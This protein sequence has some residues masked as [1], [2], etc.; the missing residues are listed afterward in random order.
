MHEDQVHNPDK[1]WAK[2]KRANPPSRIATISTFGGVAD[3]VSEAISN[4]KKGDD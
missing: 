1:Q 2:Q 4:S 3:E